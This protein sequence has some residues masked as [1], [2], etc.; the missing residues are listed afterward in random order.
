[1]VLKVINFGFKDLF[2]DCLCNGDTGLAKDQNIIKILEKHNLNPDHTLYIGDTNKDAEASAK[3]GVHFMFV[4]YGFG[5][6]D[7]NNTLS[8][9]SFKELINVLT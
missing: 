7:L 4:K 9:S 5:S 8:I 1:M 2:I 6:V 3:A